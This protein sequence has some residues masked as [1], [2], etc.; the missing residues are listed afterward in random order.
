M[1]VLYA[2]NARYR[3]KCISEG[4]CPHCGKLCAPYSICVERRV[5][6]KMM[7]MLSRMVH[8]GHLVRNGNLYSAPQKYPTAALIF[9]RTRDTDRRLLPRIRRNPADEETVFGEIE[10]ILKARGQPMTA[11]EIARDYALR[12]RDVAA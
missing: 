6:K 2:K 12:I 7:R 8:A 5:Y 11:S 9:Y 3:Q 10:V 1:N 4:R